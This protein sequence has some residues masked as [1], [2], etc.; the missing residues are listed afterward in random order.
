M[1]NIILTITC[2]RYKNNE[3]FTEL[4]ISVSEDNPKEIT[5]KLKD[6]PKIDKIAELFESLE[7]DF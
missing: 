5:R 2:D 4:E 3:V 7:E 1:A 6:N